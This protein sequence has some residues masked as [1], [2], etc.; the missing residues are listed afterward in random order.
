LTG[1]QKV[2]GSIP[3]SSTIKIKGLQI[4][5]CNPFLLLLAL[6]ILLL[7]MKQKICHNDNLSASSS[8]PSD[9]AILPPSNVL[10][11]LW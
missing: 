1:S 6:L 8:H 10:N 9:F 7:I 2:R 4:L 11:K 3:R 5:I